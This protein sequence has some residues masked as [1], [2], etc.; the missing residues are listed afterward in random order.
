MSSAI[1]SARHFE[2]RVDGTGATMSEVPLEKL[3]L[4]SISDT[5]LE[6]FDGEQ[7]TW[8]NVLPLI[9]ATAEQMKLGDLLHSEN[10]SLHDSMSALEM[11]DPQMDAGMKT[12]DLPQPSPP[13][14]PLP[15]ADYIGVVDEVRLADETYVSGNCPHKT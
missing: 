13:P 8:R 6:D 10:F 4:E 11:M 14:L 2:I 5:I 7:T 12:A 15:P 3:S 1:G 9:D